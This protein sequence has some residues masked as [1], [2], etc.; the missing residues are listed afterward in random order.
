VELPALLVGLF[1]TCCH[2][3]VLEENH[4]LSIKDLAELAVIAREVGWG[5]AGLLNVY[6][7]QPADQL[8]TQQ[9]KEGPVTAADLAVNDYILQQLR[10]AVGSQ[11]FGYLSEE[12]HKLDPKAK[13]RL[14]HD[15]AWIIDPI[16]GTRDFIEHTGNFAL[17]IALT[18]KGRPVV[19]VVGLPAQGKLFYAYLGGGTFVETTDGNCRQ[20]WVSQHNVIDDYCLISSRTHRN[21]RFNQLL[22]RFPCKNQK[23]VGSIGCK[24]TLLVQQQAD[25]YVYL[26]GK[27]AA[28]DWD[29]AAPEL[30]LTE[31]GGRF[32]HSDGSPLCYNQEDVNQWGCLVAS[33]GI[34]HPALCA[35]AEEI[36]KQLDRELD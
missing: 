8:R 5:A 4:L 33:N 15:W 11:T 17:H 25:V 18:Y 32:T 36:L 10:V 21:E 2:A 6:H 12:T 24:I 31:A 14:T 23:Y 27:T 29:F 3:G 1:P 26:S 7:N 16:D 9:T 19:A 20:V 35:E 22:K 30:I 28:K 34:S 13:K